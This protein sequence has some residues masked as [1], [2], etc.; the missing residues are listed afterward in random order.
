MIT[1]QMYIPEVER[2]AEIC[3]NQLY[4]IE[5]TA[6]MI[7]DRAP[8]GTRKDFALF[9]LERAAPEVRPFA[10]GLYDGRDIVPMIKENITK[11]Y[12]DY[13]GETVVAEGE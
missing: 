6:R 10:F 8:K 9:I 2:V 1:S 3:E 12:R 7:H 11:N 5:T 4:L 13:I